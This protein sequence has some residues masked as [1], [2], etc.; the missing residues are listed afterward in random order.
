MLFTGYGF[1]NS[2]A[3]GAPNATSATPTPPPRSPAQTLGQRLTAAIT[4]LPTTNGGSNLRELP[5][6]LLGTPVLPLPQ[7][8]FVAESRYYFSYRPSRLHTLHNPV[9][10][11]HPV[12]RRCASNARPGLQRLHP[13]CFL[14]AIRSR[15][16]ST[17][18]MSSP[19]SLRHVLLDAGFLGDAALSQRAT[20][21]CEA[22]HICRPIQASR[23]PCTQGH[24]A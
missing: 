16:P 15:P 21:P 13:P 14:S 7:H 10:C 22:D 17:A 18:G 3:V 5:H 19:R 6:S 11:T 4:E 2:N 12:G 1:Q 8:D 9:H 24:P 20:A 23:R